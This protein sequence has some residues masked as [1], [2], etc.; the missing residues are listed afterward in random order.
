MENILF[1][2]FVYMIYFIV[3]N[4]ALYRPTMQSSTHTDRISS[5]GVD[6]DFRTHH[7]YCTHTT[8]DNPAWWAI[9]LDHVYH[10][11]EIIITNREIQGINK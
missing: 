10:I 4:V 8:S 2:F 11:T 6:D 7:D 9:Q 1:N 3:T 5:R